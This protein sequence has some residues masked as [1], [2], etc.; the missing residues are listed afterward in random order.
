VTGSRRTLNRLPA[1]LTAAECARLLRLPQGAVREAMA[2]GELTTVGT[3]A[4]PAVDTR[5]LLLELGVPAPVIDRLARRW[6]SD[7]GRES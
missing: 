5:A 7:T 3:P 4:G 2:N 6:P 1:Q